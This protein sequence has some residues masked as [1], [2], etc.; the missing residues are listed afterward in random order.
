[1]SQEPQTP[2]ARPVPQPDDETRSRVVSTSGALTLA[3]LELQLHLPSG[4]KMFMLNERE[5]DEL[6]KAADLEQLASNLGFALLGIFVSLLVAIITSPPPGT[7]TLAAF[8]GVMFSAGA[9]SLVALVSWILQRR[10]RLKKSEEIKKRTS[11]NV[12]LPLG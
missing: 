2:A 6:G 1:M 10:T 4:I 5:L 7:K 8:W 9:L 12:Q 3:H 11:R